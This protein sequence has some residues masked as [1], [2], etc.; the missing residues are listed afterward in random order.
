MAVN[1][2][3]A[4]YARSTSGRKELVANL[5]SDLAKAKN[6]FE[7]IKEIEDEVRKYWVGDDAN[8]FIAKL[9][10]KAKSAGKKCN[11]YTSVIQKTLTEEDKGFR[12]MQ[13]A[14]KVF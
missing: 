11:S 1:M 12:N 5:T 2:S 9:T 8:R 6:A 3:N 10:S 4:T 13:A 14:N 7:N